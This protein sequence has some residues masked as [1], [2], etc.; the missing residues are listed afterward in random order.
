MPRVNCNGLIFKLERGAVLLV[1]FFEARI[2]SSHMGNKTT[3]LASFLIYLIGDDLRQNV[4][5][6]GSNKRGDH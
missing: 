5:L 4:P 3:K 6:F 1:P 2:S